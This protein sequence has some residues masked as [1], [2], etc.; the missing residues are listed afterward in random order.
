MWRDA[1]GN[2]SQPATDTIRFM[3]YVP[4]G[5]IFVNGVQALGAPNAPQYVSGTTVDLKIVADEWPAEGI[6][7]IKVYGSNGNPDENSGPH[8]L[9]TWP[10][11][12][13]SMT[14]PWSLTS[15]T[16]GYDGRDGIRHIAVRFFTNNNRSQWI[17][18]MVLLDRA[19]PTS[20][21][22]V[23]AVAQDTT[24]SEQPGGDG[25]GAMAS[26]RV[27]TVPTNIQWKG[28]DAASGIKA[29]DLDRL[30][31]GSWTD[32]ALAKPTDTAIRQSVASGTQTQFRV[33]ATD[34]AG[35]KG[36]WKNGP[37]FSAVI[38]QENATGLTYTGA[39]RTD[40][41]SDALG[42]SIRTAKAQGASVKLTFTGRGIAIVA[43]RGLSGNIGTA[44]VYIDGKKVKS[45]FFTASSL[46]PRRVVFTTSWKAKGKHTI[47]L[48]KKYA[49][50]ALPI[51]AFV[52]L[53]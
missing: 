25:F 39:W 50:S 10:A 32:V 12:A 4:V 45:V 44:D 42:G 35:N 2:W 18:G 28:S 20:D 23:P 31:N 13:T 9:K 27:T 41:R 11:G 29:F 24:V 34:K 51:D 47:R 36:A 48:V 17:G 33:Q 37:A 43:P 52:I 22:P 14:I 19:V 3:W 5:S 8:V 30:I 7:S 38:A 53:N 46:Q 6:K 26:A 21:T 49:S 40:N 16:Y 1:A 15:T